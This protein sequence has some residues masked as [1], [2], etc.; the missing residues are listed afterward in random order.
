MGGDDLP[1]ADRR[2]TRDKDPEPG[3]ARL[4][5][6]GDHNIVAIKDQQAGAAVKFGLSRLVPLAEGP[7]DLSHERW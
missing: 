6:P 3:K 1:P 5:C 4:R 2:R 7:G